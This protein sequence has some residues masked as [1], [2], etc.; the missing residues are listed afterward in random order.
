LTAAFSRIV[1]SISSSLN[2][3]PWNRE[4]IE[5]GREKL[6]PKGNDDDILTGVEIRESADSSSALL[7]I[8]INGSVDGEEKVEP[9]KLAIFEQI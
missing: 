3:Y 9:V 1:Y 6:R 5:W 4:D 8:S 2:L 7:S